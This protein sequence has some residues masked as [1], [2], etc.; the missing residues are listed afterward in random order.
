MA[1]HLF[2]VVL[3]LPAKPP[4]RLNG[5]LY[6]SGAYRHDNSES[7]C[8]LRVVAER[9]NGSAMEPKAIAIHPWG[10]LFISAGEPTLRNAQAPALAKCNSHPTR[11]GK[12]GGCYVYAVD[13]DV[14][15]SERR[16]VPK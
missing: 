12:D 14:V 1:T 10:R 15:I 3:R 13:N 7:H 9:C 11:K 2:Q 8:G 5:F 16:M 4:L 6:L